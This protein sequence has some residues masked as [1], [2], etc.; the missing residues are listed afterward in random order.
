MLKRRLQG[1]RQEAQGGT[2]LSTTPASLQLFR[3]A[4]FWE[5]LL[6]LLP[7]GVA[8]WG[9]EQRPGDRKQTGGVEVTVGCRPAK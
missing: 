9:T 4:T 2:H 7:A 3:C 6:G 5:S 8:H 1:P